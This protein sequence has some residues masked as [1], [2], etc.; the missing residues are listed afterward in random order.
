[1]SDELRT[2]LNTGI[3]FASM[4][5]LPYVS[6]QRV[7]IRGSESLDS[8]PARRSFCEQ[9]MKQ[10]INKKLSRRVVSESL[11]E[12]ITNNNYEALYLTGK[13]TIKGVW[14]DDERCKVMFSGSEGFRTIDFYI[15]DSGEYPFYFNVTKMSDHEFNEEGEK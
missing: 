1:M 10:M 3:I 11:F 5:L 13:E 2:W 7:F 14:S 8:D 4:L 9:V 6:C 15:E 12:L